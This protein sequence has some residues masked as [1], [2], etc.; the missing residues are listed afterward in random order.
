[1]RRTPLFALMA[2][3]LA[4]L[5]LGLVACGGD[6]DSS[7]VPA[8]PDTTTA[9]TTTAATTATTAPAEP[10]ASA[11]TLD[12]A[13]DPDGQLA[14]TETELSTTAGTVTFKLTNDSVVPHDIAV[15]GNGIDSEP[16]K[17]IQGGETAELTV[18]L[19]AGEY[20]YYCTV[21][22]HEQAGMK[23]TLTVK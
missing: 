5:C 4:A 22:G 14:Y 7:D 9:A 18:K 2:V 11:T 13:A 15:K 3:A 12:V 20:V 16:S 1:M 19:P 21:P 17:T 6:D 10:S 23:G 8:T